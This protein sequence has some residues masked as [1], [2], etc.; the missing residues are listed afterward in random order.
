MEEINIKDFLNYLK[1]YSLMIV[2]IVL[3]CILITGIY[4]RFF[5][6][7]LYYLVN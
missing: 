2:C 7:P 3:F 6:V 4:V 5:K 1:K